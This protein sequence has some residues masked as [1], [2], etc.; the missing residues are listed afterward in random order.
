MFIKEFV[1]N[2]CSY[3][4]QVMD[5]INRELQFARS[6]LYDALHKG[7]G[8]INAARKRVIWLE[9]KMGELC[10]KKRLKVRYSS[11]TVQHFLPKDIAYYSVNER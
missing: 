5:K 1:P 3:L 2:N 6:D 4:F 9:D 8:D 10:G 7:V 11:L